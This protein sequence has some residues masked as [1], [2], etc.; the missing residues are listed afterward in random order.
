MVNRFL[1]FRLGSVVESRLLTL[2]V[3]TGKPAR[4][5]DVFISFYSPKQVSFG[6]RC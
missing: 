2:R 4:V 3:S 6:S 5:L 1:A